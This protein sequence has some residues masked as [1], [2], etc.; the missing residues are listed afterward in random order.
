[1][2]QLGWN[3]GPRHA[4][5]WGLAKSYTKVV[6]TNTQIEH[7]QDAIALL[8]LCWS[9]AKAALPVEITSYIEKS[10]REHDL[11]RI[12]TRNVSEGSIYFILIII[13]PISLFS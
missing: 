12:A 13:Q 11:P 6:D 9:I 8:T 7:D 2:V 3:S 1:M 4:Q 10:L 5:V